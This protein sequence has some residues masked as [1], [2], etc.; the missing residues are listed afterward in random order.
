MMTRHKT[1]AGRFLLGLLACLLFVGGTDAVRAQYIIGDIQFYFRA[2]M[3]T[4][5]FTTATAFTSIF[6]VNGPSTVPQLVGAGEQTGDFAAVPAGT[7]VV[8][9]TFS[10]APSSSV[11]PLWSFTAGSTIYS[12]EANSVTV[13]YHSAIF[14][15]IAGTGT[16]SI[17]GFMDADC[18]WDLA[19]A[20]DGTG[21]PS[22]VFDLVPGAV[23]VPEPSTAALLLVFLPVAWMAVGAR[24]KAQNQQEI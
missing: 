20:N 18:T 8:F 5:D 4:G 1:F 14:L 13:A 3:D 24:R 23:P 7:P 9:Q 10:F 22:F 11:I 21:Q 6:G 12:F 16:M 2:T 19:G 17:T 15:D